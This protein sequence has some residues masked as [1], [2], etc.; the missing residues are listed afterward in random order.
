MTE[1]QQQSQ[2]K[3]DQTHKTSLATYNQNLDWLNAIEVP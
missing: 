3:K 2:E 1:S